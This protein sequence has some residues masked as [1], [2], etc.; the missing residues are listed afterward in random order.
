VK[1]RFSILSVVVSIICIVAIVIV[2]FK[3]AERYLVSDGKTQALF[4]I[5]LTLS[6]SYKYLLILLSFLAMYFAY[7][8]KRKQELKQ[9]VWLAFLLGIVSI[10][11]IF[12]PVWSLLV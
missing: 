3:I 6:F 11:L 10:I 12:S 5:V 4:G 1:N 8:G 7:L 9:A 2:N